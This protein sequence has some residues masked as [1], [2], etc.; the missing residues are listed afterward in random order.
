MILE[1]QRP[2]GLEEALELL[3]RAAPVSIPLGG[4]TFLSHNTPEN[5]AL[6]DLQALGLDRV[7]TAGNALQIGAAATLQSLL[8][9]AETP[10]ALKDAVR[11]ETTLNTRNRAT[12]AGRLVTC[13]GSSTLATALLAMDTRLTWLPGDHTIALGDW[14]HLRQTL[15]PG[16]LISQLVCS[17]QARVRF[18]SVGRTPQDRPFVCVAVATWP[19]GR[20]RIALGGAGSSPILAM[21][22]TDSSGAEA[23]VKNAYSHYSNQFISSEYLTETA[24]LL[25]HRILAE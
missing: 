23:A 8:E 4:G 17:N 18:S 16:K 21:D 6:I 19:S 25:V 3:S 10:T 11:L 14:L 12:V 22:G 20:T 1:Y 5:T 15:K 13:D 7:E 24:S 9:A 2:K